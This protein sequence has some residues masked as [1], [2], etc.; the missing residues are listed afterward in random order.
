M[1]SIYSQ[2]ESEFH[3]HSNDSNKQLLFSEF[4]EIKIHNK[5]PIIKAVTIK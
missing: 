5:S 1:A 3:N 4:E 2:I